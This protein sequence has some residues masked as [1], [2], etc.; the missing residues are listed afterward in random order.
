MTTTEATVAERMVSLTVLKGPDQG[1]TQSFRQPTVRVGRDKGNDFVLSDGFVSNEHAEFELGDGG[2]RLR[3]LASRH[4]SIVV[5]DAEVE[6]L[7]QEETRREAPLEDGDQIQV[8]STLLEVTIS[9]APTSRYRQAKKVK[10]GGGEHLITAA[11]KPVQTINQRL[12][13]SDTRMAALFHLAGELNG[14]TALEEIL[15][16]IVETI[17]DAFPATNFFAVMLGDDPETVSEREPFWS[18]TR[19]EVVHGEDEELIMS[20]SIM[21]Q[22]LEN[23]ESVLFTRDTMGDEISKS[24]MDANITASMCAPL[25]GQKSLLGLML[26]DTR[27]RGALYSRHDLELFNILASNAAFAIERVRLTQDI[28]EMFE[29][30]VSASVN[31]IEARDPVTAGHSERVADY[32]LELAEVVNEV[33]AGSLHDV[34]LSQEELRELRYAAL[35]HDF[36]KI[37][38]SEDVIQKGARL[39]DGRMELIG[40]RFETIKQLAYRQSLRGYI[41]EM[42]ANR[43][44]EEASRGLKA[45][46][47]EYDEVCRELDDLYGFL[48]RIATKGYLEDE[49]IAQVQA[50]GEQY[51]RGSNGKQ[52]PYL[53]PMEVEN[54]CIRKGTLNDEE[55]VEMRSHAAL[56]EA[57]LDQ[58]PWSDELQRIPC[59]AGAH[60]EK[61]DGS[62]YPKGLGEGAILPQVR[63]LTIA[64]I[65]DALTA[66]DRP[67]RKAASIDRAVEILYLEAN[68]GKLDH[69]LVEAFEDL[70]VPR[71]APRV[72]GER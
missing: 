52:R 19:G 21:R 2:V 70:V 7:H 11:H 47:R 31:A 56:S 55:W 17:F 49:E 62:G 28:M 37:A 23:R 68:E 15:D 43:E 13:D 32:T 40:Q 60:H 50:L 4:G 51:Y 35:L 39:P 25:V 9:K 26:V 71:I 41:Q 48:E 12:G 53:T 34:W 33:E 1:M 42:E 27:G 24:I 6:K 46:D 45:I 30:F 59:I 38:V 61:L 72:P 16:L 10:Q 5:R 54:L 8:G 69:Q 57:Y 20:T 29:G 14:R 36:G 67:Y 3:D 22:A 66:S 18:R 63:M 58:I 64:D 65:F 44:V